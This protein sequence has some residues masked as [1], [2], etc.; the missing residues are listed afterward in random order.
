MT[1]KQ[2]AAYYRSQLEI[3]ERA[4]KLERQKRLWE[5]EQ[6]KATLDELDAL[7]YEN[8]KLRLKLLRN[9]IYDN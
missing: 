2:K 4:Y 9:R 3:F 7:L 8:R 1:L 6:D 5:V